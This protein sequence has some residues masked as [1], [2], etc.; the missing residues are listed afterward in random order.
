MRRT[1]I[2]CT[3]GPASCDGETIRA[4]MLAGMD[5]ARINFSHGTHESHMDTIE[6]FKR[7]RA[8][9]GLPAA[10]IADTKG[11]EIRTGEFESPVELMAGQSFKLTTY[12]R[13][14]DETGCFETFKDLPHDVRRGTRIM[15][16]D[17]LIEMDVESA[18]DTEII[19]KVINGGEISSKKSINVPGVRLSMPYIS[20]QDRADL[21][22]AVENGFD[23]V[24]ASFARTAEDINQIREEL[25]RLGDRSMKIIAKIENADGVANIDQILQ[26]CD[27]VM[28]ARGDMGVE[29][30]L[31]EIP[32]LQKML[33][34]KSYSMGKQ[35]ITATQMLES[36]VKN[37]RPT[38]AETTDVAN[39][40]FDGTSSIMLSAETAAGL[41]PVEA[42]KMMARIAE[43]AEHSINYIKRFKNRDAEED[44]NVTNAISHATCTTAHDLSAAAI[45]TVTKSGTTARM[46]SKYRPAVGIVGCT[47]DERVRRQINLSWG[48]TPLMVDEKSNTEELFSAAVEAS[49][50]AGLISDGDLVVITAGV[51]VGMSGTTNLLKVHVVG[52]RNN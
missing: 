6:K 30:P 43:R 7:V 2:I 50:S 10:L 52:D 47:T 42:V 46:I 31:E 11:P 18:T 22:F 23:F 28:V 51:P 26:V 9:A 16:D 12:A 21:R 40:I 4:L 33:I 41:W 35:V 14:G 32:V 5:A 3:L 27:G 19:C 15:I 48:V 38:R 34:K 20:S 24:A 8:Q 17:G 1:K 29:I 13:E 49:V 36:M 44:Q 37:P 45:I 39:A 25:L